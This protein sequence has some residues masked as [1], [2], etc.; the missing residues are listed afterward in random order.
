M[1]PL[2]K[3]TG[4]IIT[5]TLAIII[6]I[7][8]F[9]AYPTYQTIQK[10]TADN[11]DKL[12]QI[13]T[14]EQYNISMKKISEQKDTITTLGKS[15]DK[16]IPKKPQSEQFLI[17]LEALIAQSEIPN[18]DF[19]VSNLTGATST[20]AASST[21]SVIKNSPS[22]QF[23]VDGEGSLENIIKLY[24]RLMSMNRLIEIT[25]LDLTSSESGSNLTFQINANNFSINEAGIKSIKLKSLPKLVEDAVKKINSNKTYGKSI[26]IQKEDGFGR[27]NPFLGY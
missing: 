23:S 9:F 25:S 6:S 27:P 1:P 11:A 19:Q 15:V 12:E 24:N 7:G 2:N 3:T 14:L 22:Y 17:E 4:L 13:K 18:A 26:E 21:Q 8:Y 10:E 5:I 20:I 16:L